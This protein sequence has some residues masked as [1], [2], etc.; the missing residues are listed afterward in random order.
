MK[1]KIFTV[2]CLLTTS[3]ATAFAQSADLKKALKEAIEQDGY[4]CESI[5]HVKNYPPNNR[6]EKVVWVVCN[7]P[8]VVTRSY[9]V[10][11][12]KTYFRVSPW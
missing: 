7:D 10:E 9:K 5:M 11:V 4:V 3:V 12:G 2:M 6:G 8:H 1:A